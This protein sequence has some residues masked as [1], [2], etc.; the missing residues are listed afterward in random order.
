MKVPEEFSR[1]GEEEQ[2]VISY[3]DSLAACPFLWRLNCTHL[4]GSS[5]DMLL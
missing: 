4:W 3:N 5:S 1:R 2:Q